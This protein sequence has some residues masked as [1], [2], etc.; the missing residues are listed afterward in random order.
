MAA[1]D[2]VTAAGPELVT[3]AEHARRCG[4]S[5]KSV[6]IWKGEGKLKMVGALVD[7]AASYQGERYANSA[8]AVRQ[9][10]AKQ[11]PEANRV[12]SPPT[13]LRA[14]EW[15][16]HPTVPPMPPSDEDDSGTSSVPALAESI[17]RK[18]HELANK[19]ARENRKASGELIE[20]SVARRVL[21]DEARAARD[22][23]LSWV[24]R[25]AAL[26]AADLGLDAD[27]VAMA[28]TPYVHKQLSSLGTPDGAGFENKD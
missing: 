13:S 21:F 16:E 1:D 7:H 22:A 26:I 4:V 18:E 5:R 27:K 15:R 19:H 28:L 8:K 3:Q 17:A 11:R 14:T 20:L 10:P 25:N 2:Q 24:P 6:T 23:W 9:E 12:M